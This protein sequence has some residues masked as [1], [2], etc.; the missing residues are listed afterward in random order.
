MLINNSSIFSK[1][2]WEFIKYISS[3]RFIVIAVYCC[4]S[5][6]DKKSFL[7]SLKR[8]KLDPHAEVSPLGF[9]VSLTTYRRSARL[10]NSPFRESAKAEALIIDH[11]L[12]FD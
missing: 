2:E 10:F 1:L 5:V 4:L 3:F 8:N 9:R 7:L 6:V 12:K 11:V